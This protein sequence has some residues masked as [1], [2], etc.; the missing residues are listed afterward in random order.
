M[1]C[2]LLI[3]ARAVFLPGLSLFSVCFCRCQEACLQHHESSKEQLRIEVL[4]NAEQEKAA[5][6]QGYED[7]LSKIRYNFHIDL[8]ILGRIQCKL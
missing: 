3:D 5:L 7:T 6:I 4:E 2:R 1:I 8:S